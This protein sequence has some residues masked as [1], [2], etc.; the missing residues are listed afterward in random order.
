MSRDTSKVACA[1]P[2]PG[3]KSTN[4]ARWKYDVV[5]GLILKLVPRDERGMEF[6]QLAEEIRTA[7][8]AQD[9]EDLG[10]VSWYTTT[11][12]LDLEVKGEIVRVV[13]ATPQRIRRVE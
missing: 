2:T 8:S 12:K 3:K 13:G 4:I 7:L 6:R 1:T 5:R 9:L 10:S 11:V